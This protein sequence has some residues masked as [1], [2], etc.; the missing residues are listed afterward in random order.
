MFSALSEPGLEVL[1]GPGCNCLIIGNT[2]SSPSLGVTFLAEE[3]IGY[4]KKSEGD[5]KECGEGGGNWGRGR[6]GS[7]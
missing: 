5:G 2:S 7:G 1:Q 3:G 6:S 4:E